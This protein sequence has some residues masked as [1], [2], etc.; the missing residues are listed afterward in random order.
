[1]ISSLCLEQ[2]SYDK[3]NNLRPLL[4]SGTRRFRKGPMM[5][6]FHNIFVQLVIL[7]YD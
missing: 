5:L 7:S 4:G 1:M 3:I 6:K 2:I